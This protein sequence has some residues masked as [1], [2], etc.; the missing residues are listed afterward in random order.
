MRPRFAA[1]V[2]ASAALC[3]C[4]GNVPLVGD[5]DSAQAAEL[6]SYLGRA[7]QLDAPEQKQELARAQQEC[8]RPAHSVACL[9]LGGLYAQPAA[10]LRNDPRA[11]E[12]LARQTEAPGRADREPRPLADLAALLLVQVEERIRIARSEEKK[13]EALRSTNEALHERVRA[14]NAL[15]RENLEREDRARAAR[16]RRK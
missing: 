9:R 6:M 15:E 11:L 16:E 4:G 5:A 13:Q 12:L 10:A 7:A 3:G 8:A 14:I 1:C 2:F